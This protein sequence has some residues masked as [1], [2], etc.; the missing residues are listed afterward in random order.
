MIDEH[1]P[2]EELAL[3]AMQALPEG[4]AA[5]IRAHLANCALCRD[6]LAALF[7]D[8]AMVGLSVEQYP[9]P[10]GARQRFL[11]RIAASA[12][13]KPAAQLSTCSV[14]AE[15]Q[16][17][18]I[19]PLRVRIAWATAA[20]LA[21]AVLLLGL[22]IDSLHQQLRNDA[23]RMAALAAQSDRAQRVLDLLTSSSAQH[24]LL[25]ANKTPAEPTG[26]AVYL[27]DRGALIFQA[28]NLKP[29]PEDRTYELW[30]I[31]AN[32]AAPIPAGLFRPDAAGSANV[33]LPQIP[34]GVPAK[35]LG[36]TVEKAEGSTTPTAP[37]ILSGAASGA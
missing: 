12:Q 37:I 5:A 11:D 10:Q 35:A 22:N 28:N 33:V 25:T 1:I 21:A 4:G 26:R 17:G 36:V 27:A 8:L 3:H 2:Q 31:P 7:G 30:V 14:A 32:G 18:A 23:Q 24:M 16:T 29:L 15:K 19:H 13:E 20:M 6:E 34:S 9:L